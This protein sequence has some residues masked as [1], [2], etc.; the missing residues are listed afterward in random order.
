MDSLNDTL[1]R[2][3]AEFE[4]FKKRTVKEKETIYSDSKARVI[5]GFLPCIDSIEAMVAV[6][7]KADSDTKKGIELIYAQFKKT[8]EDLGVEEI[9]NEKFD[10]NLHNAVM[11]VEDDNYGKEEIV[12]VFQKGYKMND[13]IIRYSMVKVAN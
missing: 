7:S 9:K 12:E 10:P 13:K 11:H 2:T 3:A 5:S 8:L 6:D 1:L 4:N